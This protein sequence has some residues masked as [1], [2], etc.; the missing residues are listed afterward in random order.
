MR[1]FA[2]FL[3]ITIPVGS[4]CAADTLTCVPPG[5]DLG[6]G[7][8]VIVYPGKWTPVAPNQTVNICVPI[9]S[10]ATVLSLQCARTQYVGPPHSFFCDIGTPCFGG[11]TFQSASRQPGPS[12]QDNICTTF[13]NLLGSQQSVGFSYKT[14]TPARAIRMPRPPR[15]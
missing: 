15:Q 2:Y 1:S 4:A 5:R 10:K 9:P 13:S 3:A 7:T 12:G 6:H 14:A 11:G 8:V